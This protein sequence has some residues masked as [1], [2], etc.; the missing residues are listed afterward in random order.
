MVVVGLLV[1]FA[2]K[3]SGQEPSL[4]RLRRL[5]TVD[6][7][8]FNIARRGVTNLIEHQRL[9]RMAEVCG[10]RTTAWREAV[11]AQ[12][13]AR[14]DAVITAAANESGVPASYIAGYFHGASAATWNLSQ[15]PGIAPDCRRLGEIRFQ[16]QRID[17]IYELHAEFGR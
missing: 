12:T 11:Y 4:D 6:G 5:E 15:S 1:L 17:L 10:L 13:E 9:A 14:R 8:A 2:G 7:Q 3:A 16:A